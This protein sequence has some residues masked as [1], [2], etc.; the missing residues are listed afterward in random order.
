MKDIMRNIEITE[1]SE[2]N[3][4]ILNI[5]GRIVF[6]EGSNLL[7]KL[8]REIVERG[9]KNLLLDFLNVNY[10]D[11]SGLGELVGGYVAMKKIGGEIKLVNLTPNVFELMQLTRLSKVFE[12]YT[13]RQNALESFDSPDSQSAAF[14]PQN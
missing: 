12:I 8:L 9:E 13:S 1:H 14:N 2:N 7:H 10:I 4:L 11:S 3:I 5:N 6:G